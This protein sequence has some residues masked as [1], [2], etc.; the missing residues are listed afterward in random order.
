VRRLLEH[1][2]SHEEKFNSFLDEFM[3]QSSSPTLIESSSMDRAVRWPVLFF[4]ASGFGWLVVASILWFLSVVQMADP[5]AWWSFSTVPWLT[6]GRIYPLSL[7]LLVYG[8]ASLLGIGAA[9]WILARMAQTPLLTGSLPLFAGASWNAGLLLA[10]WG[11]LGGGSTGREWLEF[12]PYAAFAIFLAQ[13]IIAVWAIGLC[14]FRRQHQLYISQ[15]YLLGAFIWFPWFYATANWLVNIAGASGVAQSAIQWWYFGCLFGLWLTPLG[16][17]A[18]FYF[19]PI[20]LDRPLYSERLALLGFWLLAGLA[21]WTG[22]TQIIGGPL[23]AWMITT[24]IAAR[25]LLAISILA[26]AANLHLTM[27][28][29]FELIKS[30]L[31]LRFL[32]TGAMLYGL[33]GIW[34]AVNAFRTIDGITQFTLA[35]PARTYLTLFGFVFFVSF[36]AIYFIVPRL[37]GRLWRFAVLVRWHFWLSIASLGFLV[38]DLTIAGVLQGFGL[39]DPKVPIPA[40][41]DMIAPFV[42]GQIVAAIGI[43]IAN[44]LSVFSMLTVLVNPD[45]RASTEKTPEPVLDL[46]E[47]MPVA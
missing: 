42:T 22:F 20:I 18:A 8:S 10:V 19:I 9:I 29:Q 27:R 46:G 36:G 25:V 37:L 21:A 7:D 16:L 15:Y 26:V 33:S 38:F 3:S 43:V 23:P 31:A 6:Y 34:D 14:L 44:I 4:F 40:I 12:P 45:W 39:M 24:S 5:S 2:L 11:V 1:Q 41:L 32:M 47:E 30:N 28:G 35:V 13:L 17:A